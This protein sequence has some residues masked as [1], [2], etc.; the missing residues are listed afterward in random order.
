LSPGPSVVTGTT[1][2][3]VFSDLDLFGIRTGFETGIAMT[4][5]GASPSF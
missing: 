5:E 2:A 1:G 3:G 4:D